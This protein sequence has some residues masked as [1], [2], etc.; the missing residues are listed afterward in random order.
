MFVGD[1]SVSPRAY[2]Q[3]VAP[4][5]LAYATPTVLRWARESSGYSLEE[6]AQKIGVRWSKLMKVEEG[7]DLLT[8]RQAERA[9]DVY[10][11]PLAAL[12]M[13]EPPTEEPQEAQFRRLRD[14][15]ALPWPAAMQLLARRIRDRQEAAVELYEALGQPPPWL[16]AVKTFEAADLASLPQVA[17][18]VLGVSRDEQRGWADDYAPLRGWTDAVEALGVL[19]MQ[20]GSMGVDEMRGFASVHPAVPAI[21]ANTQDE[22]RARAFTVVHEF[23]HLVLAARGVPAGPDTERWCNQFAGAV[24]MPPDWFA[25]AFRASAGRPL[26]AR[27]DAL[28]RTFGVT[29]LAAAVNVAQ[30]GL[31]SHADTNATI[32]QIRQRAAAGERRRGGGNYYLNQIASFGPG[33]IRLVFSALDSQAV[34]YPTASALLGRVKVNHFERLRDE[35]SHRA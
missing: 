9:A 25:E 30:A 32:D 7:A 6:A 8:L 22:P 24:I 10:E 1:R 16:E 20:D 2:D 12:F 34:T 3:R 35:L 5:T 23:G 19:V 26:L 29:P 21:V 13:A 11:R 14:A 18:T 17:R 31:A 27:V 28:S 33:F 15:P 4:S